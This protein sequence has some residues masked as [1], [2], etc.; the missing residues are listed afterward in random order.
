MPF[1]VCQRD[2]ARKEERVQHL[3]DCP[4]CRTVFELKEGESMERFPANHFINNMLDILKIQQQV[5]KWPCESCKARV[6]ATSRCTDCER[7][8][9]NNCL[10]THS[11]WP[12]F[13]DHAVFSLEEL[14]KPENQAKSKA[15]LRCSKHGHEN[16][17]YAF[18]CDSCE[19]LICINCAV[20]DHPKPEHLC[21]PLNRVA[22]EH[23]ESLKTTS[24][25][26]EKKSNECKNTLAK[27]KD[28]SK[29][30]DGTAEKARQ[31]ILKQN[32]EILNEFTRQLEV[33]T[34]IL[35]GEVDE[36][37]QFVRG[38]LAKQQ[39]D[40]KAYVRKVNGS[41]DL[42]K[43]ILEKGSDEEILSLGKKIEKNA[44][45]IKKECPKMMRPAHN[46]NV[47]YQVKA[48]KTIVDRI[49]LNDI[50]IVGR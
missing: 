24:A 23:R 19:E 1:E 35:L 43:T 42:T 40:M 37:Y 46:G 47:E 31:A 22:D 26:L 7:Y 14:A 20:L 29:L 18:Y 6:P 34:R 48:I 38:V 30:L 49:N 9:C 10:R 25:M 50:G 11:N 21:R 44:S 32:E 15:K 13:K 2:E 16:K 3:F 4:V 28:A 41:L 33:K 5:Q 45:D 39:G 8:L 27:I 12:D 36:N 17:I